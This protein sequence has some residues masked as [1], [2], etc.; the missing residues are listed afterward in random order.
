MCAQRNV[1]LQIAAVALAAALPLGGAQA[2]RTFSRG[3]TFNSNNGRL[4]MPTT[5]RGGVDGYHGGGGIGPGWYHGGLLDDGPGIVVVAPPAG[6]FID[7]GPPPR[8]SRNARRRTNN[9]QSA[10]DRELVPDEVIF[11]FINGATAAQIDAFRRRHRLTPIEQQTFHLSGTT[12]YRWRIPDRRSV[13]TVVRTLSRDRLVAAVQGNHMFALQDERKPAGADAQRPP[14]RD[15]RAGR[16][17][18]GCRS[19][20]Q[21]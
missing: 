16:A 9:S 3:G 12:F 11:E 13:A 17:D 8:P 19:G 15:C 4:T 5:P 2:Q 18:P 7:D 10:A 1:L 6:R 21:L 20:G 14:H